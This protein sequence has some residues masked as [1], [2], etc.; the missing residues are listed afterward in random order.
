M[1]RF[2]YPDCW[3]VVL[4]LPSSIWASVVRGT[5]EGKG[6]F[7]GLVW[8]KWLGIQNAD[9]WAWTSQL[10]LSKSSKENHKG[11]GIL[12]KGPSK[13]GIW[14]TRSPGYGPGVISE[15]FSQEAPKLALKGSSKAK[16]C[17]PRLLICGPGAPQLYLSKCVRETIEGMY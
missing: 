15:Q 12:L 11:N 3:Y 14:V 7:E 16:I 5:I 4:E 13:S 17:L 6:S 8:I 2:V 1:Q 10:C 9:M